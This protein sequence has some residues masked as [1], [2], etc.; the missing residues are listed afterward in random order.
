MLT[1]S[2]SVQH[3]WEV[4][5]PVDV[6]EVATGNNAGTL[7]FTL[8]TD[9]LREFIAFKGS[10]FLSPVAIG[11]VAPQDLHGTAL[12]TGPGDRLPP[13]QFLAQAGLLAERRTEEGVERGRG[14]AAAGFQRVQ[15]R[16]ARWHGDQAVHENAL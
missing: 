15:F 13:P 1:G 14:N 9:S 10:G 16:A 2:A 6:R 5:D 12:P 11:P 7:D 8:A 3:V 4:T